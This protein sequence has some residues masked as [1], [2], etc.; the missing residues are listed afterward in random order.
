MVEKALGLHVDGV[1]LDLEDAVP[2]AEKDTAREELGRALDAVAGASGGPAR[3]VRVNDISSGR[4]E[5]D[6]EAVVRPGLDA[7]LVPKASVAADVAMVAEQVTRLESEAG[8]PAASIRVVAAIES[9]RGLHE[10]RDI[11]L[12]D[13]RMAGLM[14]GAE[15]LALDLGLPVVRTGPGQE[16]IV[17]RSMLVL[18]AALAHIQA[19]DQVWL[20]FQDLDGLRRD[21]VAGR[22]IGFTGKCVIHPSQI[23]IVNETFTATAAELEQA[24]A[25]VAAFADAQ[26]Q[27]LGVVMLGGQVVEKPIVE[28]ALAVLD[29]K[30]S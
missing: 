25:I 6:L 22:Q 26:E 7:I 23:D 27:G 3:I 13:P 20:D 4:L 8:L 10:A 12:A 5:G 14:F 29:A 9:A 2:P 28:R 15:D 19:L 21:A 17:A 30:R 1:I 24:E 18:A 16:L 11:A